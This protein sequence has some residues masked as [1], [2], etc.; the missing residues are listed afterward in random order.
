MC[1]NVHLYLHYTVR[2]FYGVEDFMQKVR[3]FTSDK[4]FAIHNVLAKYDH[5][6]HMTCYFH[7]MQGMVKGLSVSDQQIIHAG[8]RTL[9][10]C[11][12]P[13]LW[14]LLAILVRDKWTK[15]GLKHVADHF[16]AGYLNK[17]WGNWYLGSIPME[18]NMHGT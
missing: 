18:G 13:W 7:V 2:E 11:T 5:T 9:H 15:C 16:A 4:T 14:S 10:Y 1:N 12:K 17:D 3:V 8:I 6:T